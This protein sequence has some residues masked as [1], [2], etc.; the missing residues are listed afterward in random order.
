MTDKRGPLMVALAATVWGSW[1]PFLRPAEAIAPISPLTETLMVQLA[2]SCVA[3]PMALLQRKPGKRS[4]RAWATLGLSGA[5]DTVAGVLFFL[6]MSVTSLAIATLTH[7]LAPIFVALAAPLLERRPHTW[8]ALVATCT[9]LAG[10]ALMLEPWKTGT[11]NG[12]GLGA[13][14]GAA[15]AVFYALIVLFSKDAGEHFSSWEVLAWQRVVSVLVMLPFAL[16]H[17]ATL[18]LEQGL[19]LLGGGALINGFA[20]MLFFAGLQRCRAEQASALTLMEP[21]AATLLGWAVWH[22]Q[23]STAGIAGVLLILASLYG[24]VTRAQ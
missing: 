16:P 22:E 3:L 20:G 24:V 8:P 11:V 23:L 18:Q 21:I 10:L 15:S 13:A 4:L 1:S 14:A 2:A 6:A 17:V 7:Y 12:R 5:S 9:A 19:L